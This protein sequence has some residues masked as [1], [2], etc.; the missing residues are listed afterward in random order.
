MLIWP[1]FQLIS[2]NV[3]SN[4]VFQCTKTLLF[5]IIIHFVA[6]IHFASKINESSGAIFDL[7]SYVLGK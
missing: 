3:I 2:W 6:A 7:S 4:I 1:I 5:L